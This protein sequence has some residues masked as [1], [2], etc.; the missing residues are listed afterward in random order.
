MKTVIVEIGYNNLIASVCNYKSRIKSV[1]FSCLFSIVSKSNSFFTLECNKNSRLKS[2]THTPPLWFIC[3]EWYPVPKS[4]P[5]AFFINLLNYLLSSITND[6]IPNCFTWHWSIDFVYMYEN[7]SWFGATLSVQSLVP[8]FTMLIFPVSW[9]VYTS[10]P[11]RF[12]EISSCPFRYVVTKQSLRD[13]LISK[14]N[15]ILFLT[16]NPNF[17]LKFNLQRRAN[18]TGFLW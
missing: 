2:D 4:I 13:S 15:L 9:S 10:W 5:R 7:V 18:Y 12:I 16:A 6:Y 14:H 3:S 17:I 8:C 1:F 11:C